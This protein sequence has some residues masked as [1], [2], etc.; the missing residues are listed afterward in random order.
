MIV[1]LPLLLEPICAAGQPLEKLRHPVCH[2]TLVAVG[3]GRR[4]PQQAHGVNEEA[5]LRRV[6]DADATP[7]ATPWNALGILQ[8]RV[9]ACLGIEE[10]GAQQQP[11]ALGEILVIGEVVGR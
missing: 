8:V 10:P 9:H 6:D 4:L 2:Q 3:P 7:V 11:G 1:G 5:D